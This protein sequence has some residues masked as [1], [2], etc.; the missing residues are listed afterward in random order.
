[1]NPPAA[2]TAAPAPAPPSSPEAESAP[3]G[4]PGDALLVVVSLS[5]SLSLKE[6]ER[7]GLPADEVP[8]AVGEQLSDL[9]E[10]WLSKP[11]N[12]VQKKEKEEDEGFFREKRWANSGKPDGG[13]RRRRTGWLGKPFN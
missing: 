6:K 3:A 1:M 11:L 12:C 13:R 4:A 10:D 9:E 5:L 2:A 7:G 8:E